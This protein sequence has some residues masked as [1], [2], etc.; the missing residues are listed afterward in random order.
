MLILDFKQINWKCDFGNFWL[1]FQILRSEVK[2]LYRFIVG[3]LPTQAVE[4]ILESYSPN[5]M[6]NDTQHLSPKEERIFSEETT[7]HWHGNAITLNY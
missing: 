2:E 6:L 3:K 4:H 5:I 7:S 1:D